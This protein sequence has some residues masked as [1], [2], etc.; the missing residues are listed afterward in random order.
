M[1]MPASPNVRSYIYTWWHSHAHPHRHALTLIL[2]FPIPLYLNVSV[3]AVA[4]DPLPREGEVGVF[5][6][7]AAG[8][9]GPVL[10]RINRGRCC[11][12]SVAILYVQYRGSE[13]SCM[14]FGM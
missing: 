3:I 13:C 10:T 2:S 11:G 12:E 4:R 7:L 6:A 8:Q 5:V 9:Q 1:A 14:Q